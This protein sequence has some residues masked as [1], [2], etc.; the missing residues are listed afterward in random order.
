MRILVDIGHP[1]HV[2]YFKNAISA[3]KKRGHKFLITTRDKEVTLDLLKSYGLPY[4]CTGKN[5][6]GTI[7]KLLSMFRNDLIIYREARKFKPDI[8]FSFFSPFA[9]QVGWLMKKPVIGF[10]DSEFAKLSIKL[11]KPFTNYIFTP[12]CFWDDFGR[13]HFRFNGYMESFYL[14]PHYFTPDPSVLKTLGVEHGERFYLMRFVSFNAGHDTGESGIDEQSKIEIAEY[15]SGKGKL[16]ISSESVLPEPFKKY[17]LPTTPE[18]FHSVLAYA[19]LYVG[20]GITTASECA[21]LGTPSILINTIMTSYIEQQHELGLTFPFRKAADSISKIREIADMEN[22][23]EEFIR[24]RDKMLKQ[25]SDCTGF[26]IYL[27]DNYPASINRIKA[28]NENLFFNTANP[29]PVTNEY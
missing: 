16:F 29:F 10:T 17:R 11:T 22:V 8:F 9:A 25:H 7:N 26:L 6:A 21:Q 3:L 27:L 20:E 13:K 23:K 14:Q 1:A 2:H 4:I 12:S 5:M 18:Q 15:L 19:S 24:R 28:G